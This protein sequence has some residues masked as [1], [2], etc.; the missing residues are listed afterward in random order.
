M[1]GRTVVHVTHSPDTPPRAGRVLTLD[2]GRLS[3]QISHITAA[4]AVQLSAVTR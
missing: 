1:N 3:Q 2:Q 4:P